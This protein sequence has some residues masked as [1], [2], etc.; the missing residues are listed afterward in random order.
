MSD[1]V[2]DFFARLMAEVGADPLPGGCGDCDAY[3]RLEKVEDG[4]YAN[5]IHHEDD[6]PTWRRLRGGEGGA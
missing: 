3:Q 4:I 5:T 6:C 1:D 2:R